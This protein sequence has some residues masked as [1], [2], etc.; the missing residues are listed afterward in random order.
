[1]APFGAR[2]RVI[3]AGFEQPRV[4]LGV[5]ILSLSGCAS[6]DLPSTIKRSETHD[7]AEAV[8]WIGTPLSWTVR[9]A[10]TPN[11]VDVSLIAYPRDTGLGGRQ[12]VVSVR[13][14]ARREG[15]SEASGCL[16]TL[17]GKLVLPEVVQDW[18]VQEVTARA[19]RDWFLQFDVNPDDVAEIGISV[20]G[21]VR[22]ISLRRRQG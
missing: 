16:R 3:G 10:S 6:A 7:S 13:T 17:D 15:C 9:R 21:V 8:A 4:L 5:L 22:W 18:P 20:E 12:V 11:D 2:V 1:M 19:S 14:T